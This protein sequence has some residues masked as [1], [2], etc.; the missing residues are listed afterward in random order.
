MDVKIPC[1]THTFAS[2]VTNKVGRVRTRTKLQHGFKH[3]AQVGRCSD[4]NM[5]RI[6]HQLE[7][8]RWCNLT[9][10]HTRRRSDLWPCSSPSAAA[11]SDTSERQCGVTAEHDGTNSGEG[12]VCL[13]G[14]SIPCEWL[15]LLTEY[16]GPLIK[17]STSRRLRG[18]SCSLETQQVTCSYLLSPTSCFSLLIPLLSVSLDATRH[19]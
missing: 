18:F 4:L 13:L 3:W 9:H 12:P 16:F 11:N 19:V 7:P 2:T 6:R 15:G 5:W 17:Q 14:P 1:S 10:D 8:E